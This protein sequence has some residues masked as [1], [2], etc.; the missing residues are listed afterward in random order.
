MNTLWSRCPWRMGADRVC[1]LR[2][3]TIEI[4]TCCR[5]IFVHWLVNQLSNPRLGSLRPTPFRSCLASRRA[6]QGAWETLRKELRMREK[7]GEIVLSPLVQCQR[8]EA[9]SSNSPNTN[10]TAESELDPM[11]L[12]LQE[13]TLNRD[14][15]YPDSLGRKLVPLR[16]PS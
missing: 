10:R 7:V 11:L 2:R 14:F 12:Q 8:E 4:T 5:N 6:T 1:K 16:L 15:G 3:W 13:L 9:S